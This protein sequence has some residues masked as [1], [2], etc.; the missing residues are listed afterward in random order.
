MQKGLVFSIEE[1][2]VFDGP[3]IRSTVF[4]KGC[5]LRCSWCHNPEGQSF[6]RE[7]L[8][9]RR[10]CLHCGSCT[11]LAKKLT[12]SAELCEECVTVCPKGLIRVAGT[13]YTSE[14]LCA[15]LLK[16]KAFYVGGGVTFSGGEPLARPRFLSECLESLAGRI[17][18]AVQ[19]SGFCAED[20]FADVLKLADMF[21]FD[22]KIIDRDTAFDHLGVDNG[23]ILDNFERLCESGKDFIV[24]IPLIPEVVASEKNLTDIIGILKRHD[25][26]YAEA[27]TY[28]KLAG[29]K[30]SLLG[31]EYSPRF[32]PTS[33]VADPRAL[34]ASHGI[35]LK[36]L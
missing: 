30:Y 35:E 13:E 28:N 21:L 3:G 6:E 11:A 22:L 12:G 33:D 20:D 26:K 7:I 1:F 8:V 4:F 27:L 29:A 5:P 17:H 14:E 25:I 9:N 18:T 10:E 16:N 36:V 2:S 31:R 19:T 23:V 24:R 32:D 34:F 15:K